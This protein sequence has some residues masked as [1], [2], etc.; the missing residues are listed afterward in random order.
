MVNID[1]AL[2]ENSDV[3]SAPSDLDVPSNDID[4]AAIRSGLLKTARRHSRGHRM[5]G[6]IRRRYCR[7]R[8]ATAIRARLATASVTFVPLPAVRKGS[9]ELKTS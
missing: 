8:P 4:A 5:R 2:A 7:D 6:H 3:E 9:F 1:D